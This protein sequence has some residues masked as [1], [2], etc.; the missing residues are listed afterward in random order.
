M[1]A[2]A[3]VIHPDNA[4]RLISVQAED[5]GLC[6]AADRTQ[7]YIQASG[8]SDPPRVICQAGSNYSGLRPLQSAYRGKR[9]EVKESWGGIF[10][11]NPL[12]YNIWCIRKAHI[13]HFGHNP[14][15]YNKGCIRKAHIHHFGHLGDE[16]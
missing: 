16:L 9:K 11:T 12:D 4:A 7:A 3:P 6:P 15:D 1:C 13:H 10:R 5:S 2:V 14:L 8:N